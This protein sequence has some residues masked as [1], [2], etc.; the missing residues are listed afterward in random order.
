MLRIVP[1]LGDLEGEGA[2]QWDSAAEGWCF[3]MSCALNRK[4]K[5]SLQA[6]LSGELI[7]SHTW[8]LCPLLCTA[9]SGG[10][11]VLP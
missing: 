5:G 6:R 8:S 11:N 2:G 7:C 4:A 3:H 1:V 10:D 9:L